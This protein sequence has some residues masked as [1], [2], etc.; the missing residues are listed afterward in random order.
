MIAKDTGDPIVDATYGCMFMAVPHRGSEGADWG[1]MMSSIANIA[2]P[3]STT[4]L[5]QLQRDSNDLQLLMNRFGNIQERLYFVSVMEAE[6]TKLF[7]RGSILV[8]AQR[9]GTAAGRG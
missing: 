4:A 3:L 1:T 2:T 7:A 8:S 6:S 9:H 5:E